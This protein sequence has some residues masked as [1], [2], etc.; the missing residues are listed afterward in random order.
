MSKWS[1]EEGETGPANW[2]H[3]FPCAAGNHQTP[4]NIQTEHILFNDK[5]ATKPLKLKYD[6]NCFKNIENTGHG[7]NVS[8]LSNAKSSYSRTKQIKV[9]IK[10]NH[11]HII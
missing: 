11:Y 6:T 3:I 9:N 10:I 1:Y 5:L 7:F 8:S 4:I 2:H